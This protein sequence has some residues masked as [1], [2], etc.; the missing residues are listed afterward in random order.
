MNLPIFI[1]IV[2]L[3]NIGDSLYNNQRRVH[4]VQDFAKIMDQIDSKDD[5][6]ETERYFEAIKETFDLYHRDI[7]YNKGKI[8]KST[9][10]HRDI[11]DPENY[12]G[13]LRENF[14]HNCTYIIGNLVIAHIEDE[15]ISFLNSIEEISGY[16][17]VFAN[18]VESISLNNLKVIRGENPWV[19]KGQKFALVIGNNMAKDNMMN[20]FLMPALQVILRYDVLLHHNPGLC[21][22]RQKINWDSLV[23]ETQQ[24]LI[25]DNDNQTCSTNEAGVAELSCHPSCQWYADKQYCWGN[26]NSSCQ[27]T[28]N[29]RRK[30]CSILSNKCYI[31]NILKTEECCHDE[32]A[33]G[34]TGPLR[35]ECMACK[36]FNNNGTCVEYCPRQ[37]KHDG[38]KYYENPLGKLAFNH[39]CVDKC[40]VKFFNEFGNCVTN[41]TAKN[42]YAVN[43]TCV[44]CPNDICPKICRSKD[45]VTNSESQD[46]NRKMLDLLENCTIYD[47]NIVIS[48]LSFDGDEYHGM[49]KEDYAIRDKDLMKLEKLTEI[50]GYLKISAMDR[51]EW[52]KTLFY[53]KN[54]RIIRAETINSA[55]NEG[56][57]ITHNAHLML[58]G[59]QNL[60]EVRNGNIIIGNNPNLCLTETLNNASV[61]HSRRM[62]IK[63]NGKIANCRLM[64]CHDECDSR[65]GCWS[66]LPIFCVKCRNYR[67]PEKNLCIAN[68]SRRTGYFYDKFN[69]IRTPMECS[70]CHSECFEERNTCYGSR[71][72]QC[73]HGCKNFTYQNHCVAACPPKH[74]DDEKECLPCHKACSDSKNHT[75]LNVCSG[76]EEYIGLNGCNKCNN[77]LLDLSNSTT[78]VDHNE[79]LRC[80]HSNEICPSGYFKFIVDFKSTDK[81]SRLHSVLSTN[82][83]IVQIVEIWFFNYTNHD[84]EIASICLPCHQH[85]SECND[86]SNWHCTKCKYIKSENKCVEKCDTDYYAEIT[87]RTDVEN[88]CRKCHSE[89]D[90]GCSGSTEYDCQKCR[91]VKIYSNATSKAFFCNSTCGDLSQT[92]LSREIICVENWSL[93]RLTWIQYIGG[94]III[95]VL[96]FG[97]CI[98]VAIILTCVRKKK[99]YE[100]KIKYLNDFYIT[101]N[102]TNSG[103]LPNM[104][105]LLLITESQ[106]TSEE[107]IGSGAFGVVYKGIW[108]PNIESID[109]SSSF[110]KRNLSKL[111]QDASINLLVAVKI[112]TDIS[113]PANNREL[114]EEAK[115][116]ASVDHPCCLRILAVCL[117]AHP[118]LIT[119]FMPLGCLLEFCQRHRSLINNAT[120]LIWA[121]QIACGMEYLESKGIIHCDLAARNVLVQSPRQVKIT[122]FGLAKMLDH[123]QQQYQFKGGRMPIKW[124]AI[125]CIRNRVFS[126]K[127][128]VWSYGVTL[129]EMFTFGE[130]PFPDIKAFNILEHL[131]KGQ[132]LNQPLIC[133]IDVYTIL[134]QCWLVDPDARPSFTELRKTFEMMSSNPHR[135]LLIEPAELVEPLYADWE[136]D[137]QK[138]DEFLQALVTVSHINSEYDSATPT[139]EEKKHIKCVRNRYREMRAY[140]NS[141]INN[142]IYQSSN[143]IKKKFTSTNSDYKAILFE[144]KQNSNQTGSSW[145]DYDDHKSKRLSNI[146]TMTNM[147]SNSQE[148]ATNEIFKADLTDDGY[149]IPKINFTK[150]MI[151]NF[152][153][154]PPAEMRIENVIYSCENATEKEVLINH[155]SS[156]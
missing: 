7:K 91:H 136:D 99:T 89:C 124:L 107:I 152:S 131:E 98:T 130:K 111:F 132:R 116:M 49:N 103:V 1:L 108:R 121:K 145:S 97:I 16:L 79:S 155:E 104:A 80:L 109:K 5:P 58:L 138:Y 85:C 41:C 52:L 10:N 36:N 12:Y 122:D 69:E 84:T 8:C 23:G 17:F 95:F 123:S 147:N 22:I 26:S 102:E 92:F 120:L 151:S 71:A 106:L 59:L 25:L 101:D 31:N 94:S 63:E 148:Y 77:A 54:L 115:V 6:V 88:E 45:I 11:A 37:R 118:K 128:D 18:Q 29:C 141:F 32:C 137:A 72:T 43:Q 150:E 55:D 134:I 65:Y 20:Y 114:L 74:Y 34:C 93:G 139:S 142:E 64:N 53:F 60:K 3:F 57:S 144:E 105:T 100:T 13:K 143:E 83:F 90:G 21:Y 27:K 86:V 113:D 2:C 39:I 146:T 153:Y 133:S 47:G 110:L 125:E 28:N 119:Q 67:I 154:S 73:N 129:W 68:C 61:L 42:T 24:V 70:K 126:S 81:F 51:A 140:H 75:G 19:L 14:D 9:Q 38:F 135:Y 44:R 33:G 96:I 4:K 15:D 127:S 48:I 56:L 62:I 46:L 156:I 87:N 117:T 112:L 76:P 30:N 66:P 50:Y 35:T 149:L 82:N 78:F 40:P